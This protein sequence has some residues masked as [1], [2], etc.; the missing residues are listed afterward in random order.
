[1]LLLK[2]TAVKSSQAKDHWVAWEAFALYHAITPLPRQEYPGSVDT[3]RIL[4]C[5]CTSDI[6]QVLITF[7]CHLSGLSQI[8]PEPEPKNK[9]LNRREGTSAFRQS[10][11]RRRTCPFPGHHPVGTRPLGMPLSGTSPF[12]QTS[13]SMSHPMT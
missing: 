9:C 6:L 7:C 8:R 11:F 1:M 13:I 4:P 5:W 10:T 2:L 3:K 12:G